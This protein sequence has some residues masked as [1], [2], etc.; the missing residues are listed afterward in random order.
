MQH[1]TYDI[2][3]ACGDPDPVRASAI[4]SNIVL[5]MHG[6]GHAHNT[7]AS[8]AGT[9]GEETETSHVLIFTDIPAPVVQ[10]LRHIVLP[11]TARR[12]GQ[13]A[14]AMFVTDAGGA[15][16]WADGRAS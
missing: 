2:A 16:V 15:L 8:G 4:A 1:A 7:W 12:Y 5:E 3:I 6:K 13:E 9:Y 10:W 14:I 11:T